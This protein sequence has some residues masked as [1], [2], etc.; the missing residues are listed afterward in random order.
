MFI[1]VKSQ[2]QKFAN[3]LAK[4]KNSLVNKIRSLFREPIEEATIDKLEQILFEAD[5]GPQIVEELIQRLKKKCKGT[6]SIQGDT[7]IEEMKLFAKEIFQ[8]P[9]EANN[10]QCEKPYVILLVGVNGSG[11]TT[12]CAKLA[13]FFQ[14][15][16]KKVL[17]VAADTFRAA[18]IEQLSLWADTLQLPIM[19]GKTGGDPGAII[20]DALTTAKA[21]EF[22]VVIIDT[23]GRLESKL[24]LM[25]QL[26][27]LQRIA[28]KIIPN[29]PHDI[30]L[31]LDA[32]T[33]QHALEQA[34]TFHKFT[35][36]SGL[37]LTKLDGSAKGGII[38]PIY[39]QMR[40]PVLYIGLGEKV[41]DFSIFDPTA[42][43]ETL[44]SM[45]TTV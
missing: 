36:L 26:A 11:K 29:A 33:G 1:Q 4:T 40:I 32:T 25:E 31:T 30:L 9:K 35:P 42:Y 8:I 10:L 38:L 27:K 5:L 13:R 41:E 16:G 23:A 21:Q 7:I 39:K 22:D 37:I 28:T 19:K 12:S 45:E 43:V 34:K 20:H 14:K 6:E 15:K 24:H 17:L 3:A 2:L 44:F 18:A